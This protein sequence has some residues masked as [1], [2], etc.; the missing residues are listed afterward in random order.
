MFLLYFQSKKTH[1][2][3]SPVRQLQRVCAPLLQASRTLAAPQQLLERSFHILSVSAVRNA[4][5]LLPT[6]HR[7]ASPAGQSPGSCNGMLCNPCSLPTPS[8]VQPSCGFKMKRVLKRRCKDCYFVV[9]EDRLHIICKTH[10]RHKQMAIKS[11]EKDTWIL[12]HAMQSPVRP[13]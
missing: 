7:I 1:A 6:K 8:T 10:P 13:Y 12:T 9:R 2:M 4:I 11:K 5:S 3:W